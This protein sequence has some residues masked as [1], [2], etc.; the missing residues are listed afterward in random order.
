MKKLLPFLLLLLVRPD[1][2]AQV[3]AH[4]SQYYAHP[5]WM[6][7]AL[8]GAF[9]GVVR[10]TGVYRNQWG[11]IT[12]PFSTAGISADVVTGHNIQLGISILNQSAGDAGYR[13]TNGSFSISYSGIQ[14]GQEGD[15]LIMIGLQGGFLNRRFDPASFEFGSQWNAAGGFDP[16][17]PSGDYLSKVS[18]AALDFGAGIN[19]TDLGEDKK[20]NGFAGFS[21]VHLSQPTEPFIAGSRAYLPMRFT[22]HGGLRINVNEGMTL[23][24]HF[25][26]LQQGNSE[27]QMIGAQ[28]KWSVDETT[29]LF[30]GV[31]YRFDDAVVPMAGLTYGR[32][33]LGLS[34]DNTISNLGKLSGGANAFE[35]SLSFV[36][37][38]DD[39]PGIPCPRF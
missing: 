32:F 25:L 38:R 28:A 35:V 12:T 4:F 33:T 7:P 36:L 8:T 13:F 23:T 10:V 21:A 6:N 5:L 37:P 17:T 29:S 2:R 20:V 24:P 39:R 9:D 11:S 14:L 22:L 15:H 16:T 34:Y 18:A 31:N 19:W 3:D 26:Y 1:V 30:A 27:E